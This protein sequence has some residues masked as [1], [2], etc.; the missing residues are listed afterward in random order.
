MSRRL[1]A[2]VA[3]ML[4]LAACGST[5]GGRTSVTQPRPDTSA[6]VSPPT[7]TRPLNVVATAIVASVPVF[8]APGT[9]DP[10]QSLDNPAPP[11]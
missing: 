8:S 3:T 6:P 7:T 4:L 2:G 11:Y 5:G 10:V 9:G 1:F